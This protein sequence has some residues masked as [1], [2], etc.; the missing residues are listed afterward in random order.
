ML[1]HP[2]SGVGVVLELALV[3]YTLRQFFVCKLKRKSKQ[4]A[5]TR[6]KLMFLFLTVIFA[7]IAI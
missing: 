7:Y 1:I 6:Y 5:G 2:G 4:T 3:W